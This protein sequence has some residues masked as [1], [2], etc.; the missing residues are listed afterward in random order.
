[1]P[2]GLI[3]EEREYIGSPAPTVSLSIEGILNADMTF[4]WSYILP[5]HPDRN[6]LVLVIHRANLS[7]SCKL[8][9]RIIT[10]F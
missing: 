10:G 8:R 9:R 6:L 2:L 4:I 3:K 7:S 1:M 5:I